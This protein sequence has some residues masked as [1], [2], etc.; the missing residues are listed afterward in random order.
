MGRKWAIN[1]TK[2]YYIYKV[3]IFER[4]TLITL[5]QNN[6]L[7]NQ[8]RTRCFRSNFVS[9]IDWNNLFCCRDNIKKIRTLFTMKKFFFHFHLCIFGKSGKK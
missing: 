5:Q 4:T 9:S 1:L 2:L 3:T 6:L 8:F 7:I